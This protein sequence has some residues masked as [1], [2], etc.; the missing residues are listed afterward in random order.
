MQERWAKRCVGAPGPCPRQD[1]ASM[2]PAAPP[3]PESSS[4]IGDRPPP[5]RPIQAPLDLLRVALGFLSAL[6]ARPSLTTI[7]GSGCGVRAL[8]AHFRVSASTSAAP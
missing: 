5:F 7:D 6:G 1:S 3:L 8:P 2:L 4:E